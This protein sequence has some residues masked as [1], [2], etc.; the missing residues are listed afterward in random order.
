MLTDEFKKRF[1]TDTDES[2]RFIVISNRTGR[3]YYVEPIGDGRGGDWGSYNP[4]TGNIENKKGFDKHTGSVTESESLIRLENGF[5]KV[6]NVE[7][8]P[9]SV[10]DELDAEYP[11]KTV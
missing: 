8:S 10:I 5:S 4:S 3:K 6:H 1:L 7:G 9:F 11:D 2:G